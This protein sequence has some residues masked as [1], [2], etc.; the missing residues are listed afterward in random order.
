[1]AVGNRRSTSE[2]LYAYDKRME[3]IRAWAEIHR[4]KSQQGDP[5]YNP[6]SGVF[7][8]GRFHYEATPTL[9]EIEGGYNP[10]DF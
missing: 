10:D 3:E 1:M 9:D 4:T 7:G 2:L 8:E 6:D 5:Q